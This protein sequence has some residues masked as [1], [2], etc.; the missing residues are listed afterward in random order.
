MSTTGKNLIVALL[1]LISLF[2]PITTISAQ[3]E[4]EYFFEINLV[5]PKGSIPREKS[6]E[7]LAEELPKIGIKVNLIYLDFSEMLE[8]YFKAELY[9][10]GGWDAVLCGWA[11]AFGE[12]KTQIGLYHSQGSYN[13]QGYNNA[14]VDRL[15]DAAISEPNV[16]KRIQYW[17]DFQKVIYDEQAA[18]L[19][20][21][22]HG[23]MFYARNE[24]EGFLTNMVSTHDAWN[25][26]LT[27]KTEE[28][29][30]TLIY[31]E[32]YDAE[33]L[34]PVIAMGSY[35]F[36]AMNPVFNTLISAEIYEDRLRFIPELAKSWETSEDGLT[37]TF[38][39]RDDV[40]WHD[41]VPFTSKDVKFTYD[42]IRKE[43]I[44]AKVY[45]DYESSIDYMET[46][47]D[48]TVII[49]LKEFYAPFLD[50]IASLGTEGA[51]IV[52]EHIL[53]DV[54]PTFDAWKAHEFNRNPIGT[55][56]FKFVEWVP[57][58]NVILEAN[59][60]YWGEK[61]FVDRY[62]FTVIPSAQ[63]AIIA[64][65]KGEVDVL[66]ISVSLV[67]EVD[68][69]KANPDLEV[70]QTPMTSLDHLIL[71]LH[72]PILSNEDVRWAISH[73]IPREEIVSEILKG[74]GYEPTS[75]IARINLY[76]NPDLPN[77]EYSIEEAKLHMEKAGF[78]YDWITSEPEPSFLPSI[79]GGLICGA[80]IGSI[81]T[82]IFLRRK[83]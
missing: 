19:H 41:G 58:E 57:D 65:E 38:H 39:L 42:M 70:F 74:Y 2:L 7:I 29:Y 11:G 75:P 22:Y 83:T 60:N 5:V 30:V 44:G 80:I 25:W 36:T 55:G 71:N 64:L 78:N 45:G 31:A 24:V 48:Y 63:S 82:W 46:P 8:R 79:A 28:D 50:M 12:P 33:D 81:V 1:I 17:Y 69:I 53:K 77:I 16:T 47:D 72:H 14:E 34:N 52:P 18:F 10:D 6:G 15:L 73:M 13:W 68:R 26:R 62:V 54:E 37:W 51:C 76:H 35:S 21:Y 9:D 59:P 32:S 43:S 67:D 20:L 23:G 49:H 3:E 27:D 56:P 40:K 4:E 66:G 61:P